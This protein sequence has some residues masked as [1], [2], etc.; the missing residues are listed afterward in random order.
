MSDRQSTSRE[1]P[2]RSV[3][4]KLI[5]GRLSPKEEASISQHISD[6]IHCQSELDRAIPDELVTSAKNALSSPEPI[7]TA[8][9]A[10]LS[11]AESDIAESAI[12]KTTPAGGVTRG[13]TNN[14]TSTWA[15]LRPWLTETDDGSLGQIGPYRLTEILGR[16]GMGIVFRSRDP[17][18]DRPVAVKVLSPGL[19][20]DGTARNR[21]LREARSV[22]AINH[23]GIVGIYEVV[24][25]TELPYFAMEFVDGR[26]LDSLLS[27]GRRFSAREV[28][29]IGYNI[30]NALAA[31]HAAGL[32]HRDIK[33][34]NILVE[35]GTGRVRL[36]DFGLARQST[37]SDLT[38]S[39]ALLG[40]PSYMAPETIA[41]QPQD[42]R[43]DLFSLG[44]VMYHLLTGRLPFEASTA[45]G[46]IQAISKGAYVPVQELAPET[47]TSLR[48]IVDRLLAHN[49]A[50]RFRSA[51]DAATELRASRKGA[52]DASETTGDD[53]HSKR[54]A[55]A[56]TAVVVVAFLSM[57][58]WKF[59]I[60]RGGQDAIAPLTGNMPG[61]AHTTR[62]ELRQHSERAVERRD[63]FRDS[64]VL[65]PPADDGSASQ[66][67]GVVAEKTSS[68]ERSSAND[69]ESPS[70]P[71][72]SGI[73][74]FTSSGQLIGNPGSLELAARM[75]PDRGVIK[76]SAG[77]FRVSES[78]D[79]GDKSVQISGP[80]AGRADIVGEFAEPA[81]MFV[82][83]RSLTLRNLNIS[84]ASGDED[85]DDLQ[86]VAQENGRLECTNCHF[87]LNDGAIVNVDAAELV[88]IRDCTLTSP[89]GLA[90][91]WN[92]DGCEGELAI[93]GC[94]MLT[95]VGIAAIRGL[96]EVLSF[97]DTG[98]VNQTF[99]SIEQ[100]SENSEL[101]VSR[102]SARD[103]TLLSIGPVICI[104]TEA[105]FETTQE[106]LSK[107]S[108]KCSAGIYSQTIVEVFEGDE[109]EP[110]ETLEFEDWTALPSVTETR[111]RSI[112]NAE[113]ERLEE[114]IDE[115]AQTKSE[116]AI[117][118]FLKSLRLP[119]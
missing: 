10:I 76:L 114:L 29:K 17:S 82:T 39:G 37:G 44:G 62:P 31:A 27:S 33:P 99:L 52:P 86:I 115:F 56:L 71:A 87:H 63:D 72:E 88:R 16:G 59:I 40:T 109:D 79:F 51:A 8:L 5:H 42:E 80:D 111:S 95:D 75:V 2:S 90:I 64:G 43:T 84:H 26:S 50:D 101:P 98:C 60:P 23:P 41:E 28:T 11:D 25:E 13:T 68:P 54:Q 85:S 3:L 102:F 73:V 14:K 57:L 21:F 119:R 91:Q 93:D 77:Q 118:Q 96:P 22:A 7:A 116:L 4:E 113:F 105:S 70:V 89:H 45:I 106:S 12:Y 36:M 46:T 100:E 110:L 38:A 55:I 92:T 117:R 103:S 81:S 61:P 30:A 49:P 107:L 20:A 67:S 35:S 112:R 104:E 65:G 48:T 6:C 58:A 97:D 47:P 53:F 18:L 15:D 108:W 19:L 78:L 83:A 34:A 32:I 69:S 94:V 24:S 66:A 9:S 74:C 1:C